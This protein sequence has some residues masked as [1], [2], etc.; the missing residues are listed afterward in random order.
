MLVHPTGNANVRQTAKGLFD[1][2]MLSGFFTSVVWQQDSFMDRIL[3]SALSLELGRRSFP[4]VPRKLIHSSPWREIGRVSALR[5][6]W[7]RLV[8]RE[9]GIFSLD[10]VIRDLQDNAIHKIKSGSNPDAIYGFGNNKLY[11]EARRRGIRR[12]YDLLFPHHRVYRHILEAERELKPEWAP[13][14]TGLHDS[15][16]DLACKDLDLELAEVII[17][18]SKFTAEGLKSFPGTLTPRIFTI[19]YG[20]P[21]AGP[22][23]LPTR[24]QDPLRVLY[25]GKLSQ[26]K[27]IGYLFE[28]VEL[29]SRNKINY[30]LT[31]LGRPPVATQELD[32]A[33][34]R[35]RCIDS[36][37]HARVLELMREHDVLVF[38]T[39]FDGFGLVILEAMSQGTVVI[40]TPNCAAP[41]IFD[42][43]HEGFIVPIRSPEAIARCLTELAEDRDLL[44]NMSERARLKAI[45][46][47]W[48]GYRRGIVNAVKSLFS[49]E[50]HSVPDG[51]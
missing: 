38:P 40:A 22:A 8:A 13:T 44:A 25:V 30:S 41:E 46:H 42:T 31:V 23:R 2:G 26:Q 15:A 14:L 6:G 28:A 35:C 3:P 27:G 16:E 39:L 4:E 17:V 20:A 32:R 43:G 45:S 50:Q 19:P 10:A 33:L 29:L 7:R 34:A 47:E 9:T 18:A 24:A 36:A 37:P 1:A 51:L 21:P 49:E 5:M 11:I 48:A 12:I